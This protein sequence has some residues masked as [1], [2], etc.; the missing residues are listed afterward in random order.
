MILRLRVGD[1]LILRLRRGAFRPWTQL[2]PERPHVFTYL[3]VENFSVVLCGFQIPVTEHLAHGFDG[4][5]VGQ[6]DCCGKRMPGGME[7]HLFG[8]ATNAGDLP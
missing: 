8:D 4:H 7:R 2:V 6:G 5:T 3:Q 1:I